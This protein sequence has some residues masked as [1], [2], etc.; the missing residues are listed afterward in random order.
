MISKSSSVLIMSRISLSMETGASPSSCECVR[1]S[2]AEE[3][4]EGVRAVV[5]GACAIVEGAVVEVGGPPWGVGAVP[6]WE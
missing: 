2:T 1:S 3:D 4:E 5:E 6:G